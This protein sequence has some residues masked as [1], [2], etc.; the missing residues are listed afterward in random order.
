MKQ[1]DS[2]RVQWFIERI[3]S[4]AKLCAGVFKALGAKERKSVY[5]ALDDSAR[6]SL[7]SGF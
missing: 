4:N 1:H 2:E 3:G 6:N 5:E 7:V